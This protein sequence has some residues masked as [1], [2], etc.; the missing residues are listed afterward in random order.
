MMQ[1]L[2]ISL[3]GTCCRL[4]CRLVVG[5]GIKCSAV[6][7]HRLLRWQQVHLSSVGWWLFW[8]FLGHALR[9]HPRGGEAGHTDKLLITITDIMCMLWKSC[10]LQQF[11]AV[12]WAHQ[13]WHAW[14]LLWVGEEHGGSSRMLSFLVVCIAPLSYFCLVSKSFV[15]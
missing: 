11:F 8:G 2:R 9:P 1:L 13:A 14:K 7:M 12:G 4:L 3:T 5:H 6:E 15:V 10:S